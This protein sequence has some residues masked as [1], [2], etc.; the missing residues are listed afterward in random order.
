[1]RICESRKRFHAAGRTRRLGIEGK[2]RDPTPA[3]PSGLCPRPLAV[4]VL[5]TSGERLG[6]SPEGEFADRSLYQQVHREPPL[7]GRAVGHQV[8]V[9]RRAG[10]LDLQRPGGH[11]VGGCR[12][13]RAAR[14]T[15]SAA[16][17]SLAQVGQDRDQLVPPGPVRLVGVGDRGVQR[18]ARRTARSGRPGRRRRRRRRARR[19]GWSAG[20]RRTVMAA[21]PAAGRPRPPS[22]RAALASAPLSARTRGVGQAAAGVWSRAAGRSRATARRGA[23]LQVLGG[24]E[25]RE[26]RLVQRGSGRRRR[27]SP[28]S[29]SARRP[30]RPR[31]SDVR[32][33]SPGRPARRRRP[34]GAR[35]CCAGVGAVP[36]PGRRRIR[37]PR[38]VRPARRPTPYG[39]S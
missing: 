5:V 37:R 14:T 21:P 16:T 29:A 9:R 30:P 15:G 17:G 26:V 35:S 32:A 18:R 31:R 36:H 12:G 38:P 39:G 34:R 6:G 24:V 10:P 13:S 23:I 4:R 19:P 3:S 22:R 1:M 27:R 7:R 25:G 28:G 11:R 20:P 33:R 8:R 2:H